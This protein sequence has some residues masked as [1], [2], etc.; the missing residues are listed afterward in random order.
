M[1]QSKK[2]PNSAFTLL[3]VLITLSILV[4]LIFTVSELLR[5]S[6]DIKFALNEQDHVQHKLNKVIR[7]LTND[8]SHAFLLSKTD[9]L[10]SFGKQRTIFEISPRESALKFTYNAHQSN[11]KDAKE[12]DISYVVYELKD[13]KKFPGRK[14]LYRGEFAR[15]PES[16]KDNPPLKLFA[17]QIE[18]FIIEAWN[19]DGWIKNEGWNSAQGDT[20]DKLPHLLRIKISTWIKDP[21]EGET[22][23]LKKEALESYATIVY[24]PNSI[25][26]PEIKERSSTWKIR[27]E[28]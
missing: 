24:L 15:V 2:R 9:L 5:S 17:S 13:S 4:T 25:N 16:F 18:S 1:L 7:K 3:E 23:K 19:G 21:V 8:L 12:S 11:K 6:I 22:S 20:K 10:R 28:L 27:R 26:F 14:N